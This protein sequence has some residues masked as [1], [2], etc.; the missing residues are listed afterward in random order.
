M[1]FTW[2]IVGTLSVWRVTHFIV[3]EDGPWRVMARLRRRVGNGALGELLDCFYCLSLWVA[4]PAALLIA[5]DWTQR[6]LLWLALSGGAILLERATHRD[7]IATDV[8]YHE[9]L[10]ESDGMLRKGPGISGE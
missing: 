6:A 7:S 8:I 2:L 5:Q 9:D 10:E 1:S 3:A 4:I